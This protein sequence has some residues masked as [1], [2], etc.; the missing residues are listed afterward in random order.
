MRWCRWGFVAKRIYV[1]WQARTRTGFEAAGW[2][3]LTVEP[4]CRRRPR[5][6]S[7]VEIRAQRDMFSDLTSIRLWICSGSQLAMHRLE[8]KCPFSLLI[9]SKRPGKLQERAED[10]VRGG[11]MIVLVNRKVDLTDP[12]LISRSR[13]SSDLVQFMHFLRG[14]E[15]VSP[16][17]RLSSYH[18]DEETAN[19]RPCQGSS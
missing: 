16:L 6:T 10:E 14:H 17:L 11:C 7:G 3:P 2:L 1:A 13:V 9:E 8:F 12:N 5:R 18:D 15:E 19:H 4:F